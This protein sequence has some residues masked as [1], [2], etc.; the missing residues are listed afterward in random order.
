MDGRLGRRR[1]RVKCAFRCCIRAQRVSPRRWC[2]L[3]AAGGANGARMAARN[4]CA[5]GCRGCLKNSCGSARIED[6][7]LV[8]EPH[9]MGDLAR[10]AHLVRDHRQR[11]AVAREVAHRLQHV[12]PLGIERAGRPRPR[13]GRS[14]RRRRRRRRRSRDARLTRCWLCRTA[15]CGGG[16]GHCGAPGDRTARALA[17]W[18][19]SRSGSGRSRGRRH[20]VRTGHP[21]L[22]PA[23]DLA[24]GV[25]TMS[26]ALRRMGQSS[27]GRMRAGRSRLL[28]GCSGRLASRALPPI[29]CVRCSG[30]RGRA[31]CRVSAR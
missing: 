20:D 8:H 22:K 2:G 6:A 1:R 5:R 13:P 25:R 11:H 15:S 14:S 12:A 9:A 21:D 18:P 19:T 28:R 10:E 27:L 26:A 23:V 30:R 4:C 29:P 31:R 3:R 17:R 24:T 16:D 7:A